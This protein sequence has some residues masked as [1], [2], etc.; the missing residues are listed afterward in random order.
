MRSESLPSFRTTN[1]VAVVLLT[2]LLCWILL[3]INFHTSGLTAEQAFN[4]T[5]PTRWLPSRSF[6]LRDGAYQGDPQAQGLESITEVELLYFSLGNID[7]KASG[8]AAAILNFTLG[9][10][11]SFYEL[12][13][14]VEEDG[15]AVHAGSF[16][17]GDRI[18]I[19]CLILTQPGLLLRWYT[20]EAQLGLDGHDGSADSANF[21]VLDGQLIISAARSSRPTAS[22]AS[23]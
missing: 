15:K 21:E 20:L 19:D 13:V 18:E 14:L 4:A 11:K 22:S 8:D 12:H 3:R 1:F 5:Y 17:L 16:F 2:V 9:T 10:R 23:P 6:T 7:G